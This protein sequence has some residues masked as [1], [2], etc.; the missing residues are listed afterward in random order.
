M[1]LQTVFDHL[2]GGR[3]QELQE[4]LTQAN[5]LKCAQLTGNAPFFDNL[6]HEQQQISGDLFLPDQNIERQKVLDAASKSV[7][8]DGKTNENV[9]LGNRTNLLFV[10]ACLNRINEPAV[11]SSLKNDKNKGLRLMIDRYERAILAL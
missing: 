9:V 11:E 6:R 4:F 8:P 5:P 3:L 1:L 10:E 2:R 7:L